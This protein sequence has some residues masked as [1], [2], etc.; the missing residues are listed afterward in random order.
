V[1]DTADCGG[2]FGGLEQVTERRA[3]GC[4]T[5]EVMPFFGR[6]SRALLARLRRIGQWLQ[7]VP[8]FAGFQPERFRRADPAGERQGG[9]RRHGRVAAGGDDVAPRR[10]AVSAG[11]AASVA[12]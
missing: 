2:G 8:A 6:R 4:P 7:P 9:F 10:A 5:A 11:A 3:K 1:P 12:A